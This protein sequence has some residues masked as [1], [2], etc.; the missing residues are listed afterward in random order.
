MACPAERSTQR[1]RQNKGTG[2]SCTPGS[3]QLQMGHGLTCMWGVR[4]CTATLMVAAVHARECK[5]GVGA[6]AHSCSWSGRVPDQLPLPTVPR[7][8]PWMVP[9]GSQC[10]QWRCCLGHYST[11]MTRPEVSPAASPL[12]SDN[13]SG[14][15][16][17]QATGWRAGCVRCMSYD[18]LHNVDNLGPG[19]QSPPS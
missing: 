11:G 13:H 15:F 9:D 2:S 12:K 5:Q 3:S 14:L 1:T 7:G 19:C 18:T 10:P 16:T 8:D 4:S 6:L 17:S